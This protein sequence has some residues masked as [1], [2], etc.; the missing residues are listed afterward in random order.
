MFKRKT[1]TPA[2]TNS[3]SFS[4]SEHAGPIVATIFVRAR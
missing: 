3:V 2:A 4:F 1:S